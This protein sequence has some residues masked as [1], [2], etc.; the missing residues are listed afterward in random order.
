MVHRDSITG[1]DG[2]LRKPWSHRDADADC[3]K[4]DVFLLHVSCTIWY[5]GGL[6]RRFNADLKCGQNHDT[7]DPAAAR[8]V[9]EASPRIKPCWTGIMRS[10]KWLV[11]IMTDRDCDTVHRKLAQLAKD[12]FQRVT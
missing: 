10:D 12:G 4:S 3:W 11:G 7:A 5:I 9:F 2:I 8:I 6:T 1:T